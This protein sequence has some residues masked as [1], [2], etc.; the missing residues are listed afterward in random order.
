MVNNHDVGRAL[1]RLRGDRSQRSIAWATGVHRQTIGAYETGQR[2]PSEDRLELLLEVL[3]ANRIAF[4]VELLDIWEERLAQEAP[5]SRVARNRALRRQVEVLSRQVAAL[6]S[7]L[8]EFA[9]LLG[10]EERSP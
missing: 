6:S 9:D 3:G 1:R 5:R 10:A 4:E 2:L 7:R 8:S